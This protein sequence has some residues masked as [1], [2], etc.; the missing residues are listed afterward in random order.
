MWSMGEKRFQFF[1][2][3]RKVEPNFGFT[4]PPLRKVEPNRG[5]TFPPLRK[6]EPNRG[7]GFTFLK[8]KVE[9]KDKKK[10]LIIYNYKTSIN[11]NKY[12]IY[13]ALLAPP[14]LKVDF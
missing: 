13:L 6:V 9:P 2:P 14:F 8:G 7:F 5:F 1:P 4:F 12:F 11:K 10:R 3:L